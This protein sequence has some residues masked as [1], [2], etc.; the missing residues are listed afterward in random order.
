M[1][2][3][4]NQK[5][6]TVDNQRVAMREKM[7][8]V[9]SHLDPMNPP[10]VCPIKDILSVVTDKWSILIFMVLGV[11]EALRFNELKNSVSGVSSKIL[12][13]RL[14]RMERDGY[15]IR[16]VYPE[17]PIKVVYQLS[18]FGLQFLDQLMHLTEWID[19]EA[20]EILKRRVKF[21]IL[22]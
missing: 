18:P 9:W 15:L 6:A 12:S 8:K 21:D 16:E 4:G 11:H 7:K 2:K 3:L 10:E 22:K 20:P 19:R 5:E 17:V 13:E 14:K 1:E